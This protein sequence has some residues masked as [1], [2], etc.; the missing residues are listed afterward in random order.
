MDF[1]TLGKKA[2]DVLNKEQTV[3]E[4]NIEI[5]DELTYDHNAKIAQKLMDLF[6]DG[7]YDKIILVYNKF[8]NAATQIVMNE[9]FLPIVS[10]RHLMKKQK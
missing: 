2:N 9:Q 5:F 8:K 10:N 1:F 3:I 4:N 6:T 7:A